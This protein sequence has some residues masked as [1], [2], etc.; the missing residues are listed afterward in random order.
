[1]AQQLDVVEPARPAQLDQF[2]VVEQAAERLARGG[3]AGQR[4][5]HRVGIEALELV[6]S[7]LR[8]RVVEDDRR[9]GGPRAD[10]LECGP[11]GGLGEVVGDPEPGRDR[12][13]R[14][15]EAGALEPICEVL[16]LEVAADVVH[17]VGSLDPEGRH[18]LELPGL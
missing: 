4:S 13:L 11:D 16:L 6:P 7:M 3:D 15:V 14:L 2:V 8:Q 18:P 5:A 12:R 10:S 1:V 9:A 17:V